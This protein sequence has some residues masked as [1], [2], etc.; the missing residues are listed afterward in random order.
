MEQIIAFERVV[1][2]CPSF[3]IVYQ[4]V[5][6]DT[7]LTDR[8]GLARRVDLLPQAVRQGIAFLRV[9]GVWWSLW[10]RCDSSEWSS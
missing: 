3:V 8:Q 6:L 1:R 2:R 4:S 5:D 9:C 7:L 10:R